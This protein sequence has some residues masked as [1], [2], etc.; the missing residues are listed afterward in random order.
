M[1]AHIAA[2]LSDQS[3]LFVVCL[4]AYKVLEPGVTNR[5][6]LKVLTSLD[7]VKIIK[8]PIRARSPAYNSMITSRVM[9][10]GN[11]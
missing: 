7:D 10:K 8:Q 2:L 4:F 3:E 1:L 5:L 9:R 11:K 6:L